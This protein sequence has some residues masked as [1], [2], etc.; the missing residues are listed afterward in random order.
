MKTKASKGYKGMG[1]EGFIAHWYAKGRRNDYED[2]RRDAARVAEH[3]KPGSDVLEVAP[4]PGF[5]A[6]ELAKLGDFRVT[7]LDISRTCVSIATINAREAG[8]NVKFLVGNASA[9]PFGD[10]SFDCIWC[11]RGF[12]EFFGAGEGA[13]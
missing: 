11:Q 9:M 12:Q 4:G 2:F 8:V 1:M 3:L 13:G 10:E 7:G 6:V 5:F